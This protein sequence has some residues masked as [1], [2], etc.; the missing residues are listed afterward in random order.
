MIGKIVIACYETHSKKYESVY[1]TGSAV[2]VGLVVN[3]NDSR[4][5]GKHFTESI[6]DYDFS[7]GKENIIE[8]GFKYVKVSAN[9]GFYHYLK[10]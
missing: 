10:P 4:Y 6:G 1:S 8:I 2:A 9:K 5:Y 7:F 3:H